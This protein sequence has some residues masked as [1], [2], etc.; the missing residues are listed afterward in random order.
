MCRFLHVSTV[1]NRECP[2]RNV[3]E[4]NPMTPQSLLQIPC[5]ISVTCAAASMVAVAA[6]A[7]PLAGNLIVTQND[8]GNTITSVSAVVAQGNGPTYVAG[9]RGDFGLRFDGATPAAD[10]ANG[11]LMVSI[12]EN[13]RSNEGTTPDV[14]GAGPGYSTTAIQS[15]ANLGAGNTSF[16][17]FTT[18]INLSNS[19]VTGAASGDEWNANQSFAYFKYADWLGGWVTNTVNNGAMTGFSGSSAGL[20]VGSAATDPGTFTV[21]DGTANAGFYTLRLANQ[22]ASRGTNTPVPATSQNGILLVTGGKNEDNYALSSAN[23]DG[24]FTL[25]CKDNG[26]DAFNFEN[27]PVAFVYLP[28]GHSDVAAM[29]RVDAEGDVTAGSGNY[30]ITKGGTGQWYITASGLNDSNSVLIISPEG[31][32]VSGTNRADNIWNFQWDAPNMRWVVESRDVSATA[33]ANPTLQNMTADEPAFSFA[34]FATGPVN[35]PPTVSLDSPSSGVF[36]TVGSPVT[37]T[38]TASDDTA[39]TKVQFFDGTTLLGEDTT[40]PYEF[41]WTNPALGTHSIRARAIDDGGAFSSSTPS[42]LTITPTPGTGGL[43]FDGVDDHVTFGNHAAL[44]LSTFTLEC[45]FKREAGGVAAGT[46]SGGISAIP[47][48]TK[49]RGENDSAGYNCNYF[50]GIEAATGKLAADFEDL[51]TGLN[52]P[53][54]GLTEIPVGV[55]QHAAVTFDGTAWT[56]YLNGIEEATVSTEGEVPEN[57]SIQHAGLGTAMNSAGVREGYFH[58]QMDEVRIWNTAR[59]ISEIQASMNAQVP[60]APGLIARY[61]MDETSGSTILSTAGTNVTGSMVNGVFRTAGAPFNLNVP[62]TI[63]LDAPADKVTGV[64][65]TAPLSATVGDLNG[66]NLKVTF[67]GRSIGSATSTDDFSVVALPDTQYYSENVG[68]TRAAIFS[69]QTDWI[70]AE[71]DARNIGF[72]LHLGDI[73]EHGDNPT[74]ATNEWANAS[75]A[76]YRLENPATTML[77]EGVPYILAVGNHDQTP[78]GNADGTTTNFNTFFGVHPVTGINHFAGKSYYGG[79]SEP[80][81]ADNN[82]TLFS[83]GGL[84]FIVISFE[85][86]TTPDQADLDW[87]DALLKANPSRRGIVITHHTVNTGNPASFSTQGSAI[88]Q[89]LKNNPNLILM[90]GGHIHGEGRR[91]DTFEGRTVHSLLAD[92]QGRSNGGDGWLRI[93]NF[94]PSLNR[95][96]VQTYSPTMNQFETDADSQFSLDVNLSGGVGPFTEIGSV[97]VAPGTAAL[98]WSGLAAGGRYEWYAEVS[99][100]K[101]SMTT[102]IRS[103]TADGALF[104]PA[105][106]LAS[107]ANGSYHAAPAN[108]TLAANATDTDGTVSKV[109][110]FSGTTLLGEDTSAPYSYVW[111]NVQAGS[112]TII[113]KATDNDGLVTS[114]APVSVLVLAEPSAPDVSKISTGLFNPNWVVAATSPS[115]M[116]FVSPGIDAG[117]IALK[118]NGANVRFLSGIIATANWDNP[119]SNGVIS[120]DNI[121]SAYATSA[122]N[123]FVNVMTNSTNNAADGNPTT[124]EQSAGTAVAYLPYSAGFVGASVSMDADII[125]SNLPAGV[126][127]TKQG[128]GLY[129]ITGLS[130]AGNFLAFTNGNSGTDID[131]ILSVRAENG[132]WVVDVRDNAT[133]SQDGAFS[134]V[135]LPVATPGVLSGAISSAGK[136]RSFNN[137]MSTTGATVVKT[138]DYIQVTFGDGTLINPSN[139]ALFLTPDSTTNSAA[140]DNLISYESSGNS[141]RVFSQDLPEIT[142]VFQAIDFRFVAVPLDLQPVLPLV[143]IEAT[144]ATAGEYGTDQALA[145]TVTR[146]GSTAAPLLVSYTTSGATSGSDFTALSGTVEIPAS[147]ASAVIPVTVLADDLAEG[148]EIL[149]MTVTDTA[150]YNL[151]TPSSASGTIEDRP[152]QAFLK[153]H[154]LGAADGDFDGDGE[155]NVLEYYMGSDGTDANSRATVSAIA[156]GN[157]TFTA[158]FPHAKTAND[159]TANVEWSTDLLNWHTTGQSNGTQTATVALRPV[160]PADEDPEIIEAVLTVTDGPAP[161]TIYLRLAVAP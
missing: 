99:D 45:W 17:G 147:S 102:P 149:T 161:S 137:N 25:I 43:Y 90:H 141:F 11:I 62:P 143:S 37:L 109:E 82:Y 139:T 142:G 40:S 81:K 111:N 33:T 108:I 157:G 72:V 16:A 30:Q 129:T 135:Y 136:L 93:M 27:D 151:D 31:A 94:R 160:S 34:I 75:N 36:S 128:K 156:G 26:T 140:S 47:L 10:V 21:F 133:T 138:A 144:N 1:S 46:G 131:N 110:F 121:V 18:S 96:D 57:I 29:G 125:G 20:T 98:N 68:G 32:V 115:P 95:I 28:A 55:W 48:I 9:N 41:I 119:D 3:P 130:L 113:A 14:I 145:F 44:K 134:F 7:V 148:T 91:K 35:Q 118:V 146:T 84:D 92:F 56:L 120:A 89:A 114:A 8:T 154:E 124:T 73:S 5:C 67:Y 122:G 12:R 15:P 64:A 52:H 155:K 103:F 38:A 58:G 66:D 49:G 86:D 83:A 112:Y 53:A 105:I 6:A 152:F 39:V 61:S 107:P 74:Y 71:K 97:D 104:A 76:M 153:N 63:N 22:T 132:T 78:I 79:T 159:V 13:G 123:A 65:L 59:D 101:T 23:A 85:Y 106:S 87:A 126:T 42:T 51:S 24:T 50:V 100:G 77:A 4:I 117:D 150:A 116:H 69:A 2:L 80:T 158:R 60:T 70:V 19:A 127:V 54:V 88:Y